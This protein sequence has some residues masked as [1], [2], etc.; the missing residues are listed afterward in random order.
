MAARGFAAINGQRWQAVVVKDMS[1]EQPLLLSYRE[2]K[3]VNLILEQ[4]ANGKGDTKF[5]IAAS[6]GSVTYCR[7]RIAL[8]KAK[9][10]QVQ[11]EAEL[12]GRESE[13]KIGVFYGELR[14]R[15]LEYGAR[16]ANVRELGRS[17][18]TRA[19]WIGR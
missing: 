14:S 5:V 15:G 13:M 11:L 16:F 19:E 18:W 9:Q 17:V 2:E 3:K 12:S 8:S 6:D 1:F 10:E 4:T 7:G